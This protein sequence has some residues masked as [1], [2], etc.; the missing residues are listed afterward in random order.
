M[1]VP[2]SICWQRP[3]WRLV[4][5]K[6]YIHNFS[7]KNHTNLKPSWAI[8]PIFAILKIHVLGQILDVSVETIRHSAFVW[9]DSNQVRDS[10]IWPFQTHESSVPKL[11]VDYMWIP[12]GSGHEN[13]QEEC[14]DIDEC[15]DNSHLCVLDSD[16]LNNEGLGQQRN[17]WLF[18][19]NRSKWVTQNCSKVFGRNPS[20]RLIWMWML[21]RICWWRIS[22][23]Y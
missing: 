9:K 22:R 16:C 20:I 8:C 2:A 21:S 3:Y 1:L 19:G 5:F 6:P 18:S 14:V 10:Q 17:H 7:L 23:M 13:L 12:D 4:G 11:S 15:M